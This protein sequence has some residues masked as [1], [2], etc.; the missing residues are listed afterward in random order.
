MIFVNLFLLFNI[1][2]TGGS[3]AELTQQ[4]S[5]REYLDEAKEARANRKPL[6]EI[7][8][9]EEGIKSQCADSSIAYSQLSLCF[10]E[11][12]DQSY[13][14]RNQSSDDKR[15]EY[16]S[17]ALE[18]ANQA[19]Q[20]D[21]NNVYGYERKSMAFA[22]L[23]DVQGLKQKVQLADSVRVNAEI[24]LEI[25]PKN[26]RALHILG[27]WH[28]EVSQFGGVMRFFARLLFGTAPKATYEQAL[29]YFE[30]SLEL[31]DF[32][33]HHYWIGV[34]QLKLNNN[35]S[36]ESHFKYLLTLEN[37]HHNDQFFK[38]QAKKELQK[39]N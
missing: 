7:S 1:L 15:L 8:I 36:A 9:L 16:F 38:E 35:E 27:R 17:K 6:V 18:I 12:A 33:V 37:K 30:R 32:P 4:I 14:D 21:P 39:L 34:T 19:I 29:Y 10:L 31:Q 24:A 5:C 3:R 13:S 28:Y 23:V 2:I 20:I 11:L 26:D 22:G 25:D